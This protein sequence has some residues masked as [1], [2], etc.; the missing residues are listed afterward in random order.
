MAASKLSFEKI[1]SKIVKT[2]NSNGIKLC[3]NLKKIILILGIT[4]KSPFILYWKMYGNMCKKTVSIKCD[5]GKGWN[6]GKK[7]V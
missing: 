1:T 7:V 6:N 5:T 4:I 3:L 2:Q